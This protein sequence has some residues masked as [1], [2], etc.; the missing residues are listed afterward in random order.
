MLAPEMTPLPQNSAAAL[1]Q[2]G[3]AA[4][5]A[6]DV[7]AAISHFAGA[8]R[9]AP[10]DAGLLRSLAM[11]YRQDRRWAE[12][13]SAAE[14][15]LRLYPADV[16]FAAAR[17]AA[18]GSLLLQQGAAAEAGPWLEQA[19]A[20]HPD[21]PEMLSQAAEA[22]YRCGDM[23]L[24]RAR[25]D[26][27]VTLEP[28]NRSLRMARAT[29][30]LSLGIW[31]PGLDDYE[32]RLRPDA[33]PEVIRTGLT[34]PRWQGEDMGGRCLLVTAEQGIGDQIRFA[35]DLRD[36]QPLCGKLVVECEA[37]LAPLLARSLPGAVVVAS[38]QERVGQRHVLD[39]AWL[40]DHGPVDAWIEIGSLPL[41]LFA[42]GLPPDRS[43]V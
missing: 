27:A 22:A 37:R 1:T 3:L 9:L 32:Y 28:D 18:L 33:N 10:A 7:G 34:A 39:Y 13:W 4:L 25:L 2:V 30:L 35:S 31:Q 26:R 16:G 21:W 24:A 12:A 11:L 29:M 14:T 8:R 40:K 17:A 43:R 36:L 5:Q 19:L 42:R 38:R 23:P 41:R 6:G 20:L 15:G